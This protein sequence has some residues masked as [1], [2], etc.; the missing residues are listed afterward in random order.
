MKAN[1]KKEEFYE[2][3]QQLRKT[4]EYVVRVMDKDVSAS[5]N[6][7]A[8]RKLKRWQDIEEQLK[9]GNCLVSLN[10]MTELERWIYL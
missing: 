5:G 7:I 8:S 10:E 6:K 4:W 9:Y 1:L 2:A 3:V